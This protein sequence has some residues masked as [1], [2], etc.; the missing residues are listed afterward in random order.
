MPAGHCG[1]AAIFLAP[2][3]IAPRLGFLLVEECGLRLD[4]IRQAVTPLVAA[5]GRRRT[6]RQATAAELQGRVDPR[7]R[8]I[9]RALDGAVVAV[10]PPA[11]LVVECV[12][13][14]EDVAGVQ[15]R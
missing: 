14:A 15:G 11:V 9:D 10:R 12:G 2:P 1:G 6:A 4:P 3:T 8:Q 5:V 7:R 13:P